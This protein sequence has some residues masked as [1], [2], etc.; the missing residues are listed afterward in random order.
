MSF[1]L[2]SG[3][4]WTDG[5]TTA[6]STTLTSAVSNA[7]ITSLAN[8]VILASN[9]TG[10]VVDLPY[11]DV[12]ATLIACSSTSEIQSYLGIPA[13]GLLYAAN[14]LSDLSS[15]ITARTNLGLGSLATMSS[16]TDTEI[17]TTIGLTKGGTGATNATAA[18]TA[19]GLG[20]AATSNTSAFMAAGTGCL[21][22]ANLSDV[23]NSGTARGNLG[24]GS[25][26]TKAITVSTSSASGTPGDGDLWF[27]Y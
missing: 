11:S 26:A 1:K 9:S 17:A 18:R 5:V 16:I 6:N 7:T 2:N 25:I 10:G 4:V 19:L 21:K 27:K 22:S 3:T 14:N 23:S 12:G 15:S 24:L 13:G 8:S 20:T